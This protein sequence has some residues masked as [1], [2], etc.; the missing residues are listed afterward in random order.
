MEIWK[1]IPG[2]EG[3]YQASTEGRIRSLK[4]I[5]HLGVVLKDKKHNFGYR[6]VGLQENYRKSTCTVHRLV[7]ITFIPNPFNLPQV[8]HKNGIKTDNRVENLEWCSNGQ[9]ALHALETGLSKHRVPVLQLDMRGN[10]IKEWPSMLEAARNGFHAA[11]IRKCFNGE[12]KQ[13]WGF[14]WRKANP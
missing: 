2:W 6:L 14:K 1:D 13:A 10:L 5:K 8:N 9:N 11:G 4:G 12:Y 3:F 7:A